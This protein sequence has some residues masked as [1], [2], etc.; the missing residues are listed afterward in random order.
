MAR[1]GAAL[2]ESA[3][4]R[5][6]AP[7]PKNEPARESVTL[8][9]DSPNEALR[10]A[11]WRLCGLWKMEGMRAEA[12]RRM[13]NAMTDPADRRVC[14][15]CL[16][17]LGG[18]KSVA[19][20]TNLA[21]RKEESADLRTAA[22]VALV[23]LD[24]RVAANTFV[25][26]LDGGRTSDDLAA[27]FSAFLAQKGG[28]AALT[29]ALEGKKL[30]PDVAK[31]GLKAVRSSV[32]DAKPLADALAKAGGLTAARTDYTPAEVKA[33]VDE[34]L[35][36]GDA[37]RGELVYRR[38]DATCLSCHA[39]AG[40]GGQVGPDMTSIGASAQVDYLVESIL[41]PNKAV[42][43]GYHALRVT[44][45]DGKVYVGIK[46]HEADGKVYL[47]T[48]EDKEVAIAEKDIDD[49]AQSRSLMPDGL[50]DQLT[51]QEFVDLVRFLSELGK[52]GPYAP[53]K[54]RLVRRWQVIEP[55][56]EN[57]FQIQRAR[58][59]AVVENPN[60]FAWSSTYSKANGEFPLDSLPRLVVWQGSEPFG[61]VRGQLDVTTGGPVKLKVNGSTGL[62][63]WVGSTPFEV[64]DETVVDLKPG[65]QPITFSVDLNKRKDSLR[66]ELEDVAGS[67]ARVN[68]VNGK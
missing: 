3:R 63:L 21:G 66:I 52:V 19:T 47:R 22:V 54:A 10:H 38:K 40:A 36:K 4:T 27:V 13:A 18:P 17:L 51:R 68:I 37:A 9:L 12:E 62:T 65:L 46:T 11:S 7:T 29:Q 41:M 32:Q 24:A 20:L 64:K 6:V 55:T 57:I 59:A 28:A 23:G 31:V 16:E 50:A 39:I 45:L 15:E 60:A 5:K 34:V 49:K 53:N 8:F 35:T 1:V 42:K 56:R 14:V 2:E 25:R 58:A 67:P 33:Y 43:E 30:S 48:S 26:L 44:T 61:L